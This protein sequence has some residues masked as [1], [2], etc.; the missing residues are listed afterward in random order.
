MILMK[1]TILLLSFALSMMTVCAVTPLETKTKGLPAD[2]IP[3]RYYFDEMLYH[4]E[5][6]PLT[7]EDKEKS[8]WISPTS[9]TEFSFYVTVKEEEDGFYSVID[10]WMY[11]NDDDIAKKVFTQEDAPYKNLLIEN[12]EICQDVTTTDHELKDDKTGRIYTIYEKSIQPVV[13]LAAELFTGFSHAPK[14]VLLLNPLTGNITRLDKQQFVTVLRPLS[15]MLMTVEQ[16]LTSEYILTT[17]TECETEQLLKGDEDLEMLSLNRHHFK[18]IINV[19]SANGKKVGQMPLP[20][21]TIDE[22]R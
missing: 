4:D 12:M 2:A 19:Y 8:K 20:V 21:D 11:D 10:L 6:R 9:G 16:F 1:K 14:C 3:A 22:V 17:N 15:N 7:A 18:P 13:V 5:V